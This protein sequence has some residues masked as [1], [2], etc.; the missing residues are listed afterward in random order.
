ME[1]VVQAKTVVWLSFS[2]VGSIIASQLGGWDAA[3]KFLVGCFFVDIVTGW[4]VAGVFKKS[5]KSKTG[6]LDSRVG[7]KGLCRKG[8]I[9]LIVWLG[10]LLDDAVGADYIRTAVCFGFAGNEVLSIAENFALMGVPFPK[11]ML[12]ALEAMKPKSVGTKVE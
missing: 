6:A 1:R 5:L 2:A 11:F 9:L 12:D 10:V 8:A 7:F 3:L 4:M